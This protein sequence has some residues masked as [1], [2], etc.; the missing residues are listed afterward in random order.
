[1]RVRLLFAVAA[2]CLAMPALADEG[3][4]AEFHSTLTTAPVLQ[5][6]VPLPGGSDAANREIWTVSGGQTWVRNVSHP[7]LT[8]VLPVGPTK[9]AAVIVAPGGAFLG[10]SM[11]N[12]GWDVARWLANHGIPAFILKYRT[13]PTPADQQRFDREM[14]TMLSGGKASFAPP[15]DT[16]DTA[17]ADAKAAIAYLQVNA[18]RYG[19]DADR[20]GFMGFS[21]GGMLARSVA[22]GDRASDLAFVAPIYPMM[23][24][25]TVPA[26]APPMFIALASDDRLFGKPPHALVDSWEA[27]GKPVEFHLFANGG[28]GFGAGLPGTATANWMEQF[29]LWLTAIG[30]DKPTK[31][32]HH[33][34]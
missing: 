9:G 17:L 18:G 8:P 33:V 19:I 5:G 28:H 34:R 32:K 13:L 25:V 1:M 31:D 16:P 23:N 20:I 22:T 7:T 4:P 11:Q 14:S 30:L 24:A 12:E 6:E 21:A 3:A 29:R 10:L 2:S 15:G 26:D 27:A